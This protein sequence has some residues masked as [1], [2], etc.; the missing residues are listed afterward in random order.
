GDFATVR[1]LL[2]NGVYISHRENNGWTALTMASYCGNKDALMLLLESGAEIDTRDN[3]GR[4]P[5][6][7]VGGKYL[8]WQ[9]KEAELTAIARCL[10]DQ[11]ADINSRDTRGWT[12]LHWDAANGHVVFVKMLVDACADI[13]AKDKEGKTP[14]AAA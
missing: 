8:C 11:G 1:L 9:T 7:Y 14:L 4:T 5:L 6:S 13:H 10:I 3:D 12:P 2:D